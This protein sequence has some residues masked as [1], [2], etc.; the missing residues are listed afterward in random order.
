[1]PNGRTHSIATVITATVLTGAAIAAV[2]TAGLEVMAAPI[3]SL[4]GLLLSPDL[5]LGEKG[6]L[7][8]HYVKRHAGCLAGA[9]WTAVWWPYGRI[10]SHRS[11][12]SHSIVMGTAL[13]IMYIALLTFPAWKLWA[14]LVATESFW[15]WFFGLAIADTVH[16]MMDTTSTSLKRKMKSRTVK[17]KKIRRRKWDSRLRRL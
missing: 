4:A 12:I 10:L 8:H 2:Q 14:A 11:F 9:I 1:M 15:W 7:S 6:N 3:G 16:I 5:D 17:V 13:R